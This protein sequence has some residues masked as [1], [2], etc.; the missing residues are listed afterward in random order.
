MSILKAFVG[1]VLLCKKDWFYV[2]PTRFFRQTKTPL[3]KQKKAVKRAGEY[4]VAP[5]RG[6]YP[7]LTLDLR[8][9]DF[10]HMSAQASNWGSVIDAKLLR[11][12]LSEPPLDVV[13]KIVDVIRHPDAGDAL[14]D[15]VRMY[16]SLKHLQGDVIPTV[17]GYYK[18]WG[19]LHL[20]ALEPV[21]HAISEDRV[22]SDELRS[23]MKSALLRIHAAGYLHGDIARRNFCEKGDKIFIVDLERSR[24]KK[25]MSELVEEEQC[26]DLL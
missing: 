26:I 8:L 4:N 6:T 11:D 1:M 5:I 17:H 16:A 10:Q 9:C 19:T 20:L 24:A 7:L 21:G 13:C 18:M 23:K 25:S 2:S 22:I 12:A 15:E 3:K 14:R